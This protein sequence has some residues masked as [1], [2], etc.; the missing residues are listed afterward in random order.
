MADYSDDYNDGG[1]LHSHDFEDM[2][3]R[4]EVEIDAE[5]EDE[6]RVGGFTTGVRSLDL[7]EPASE[8]LPELVQ[9]EAT[10]AML[11]RSGYLGNAELVDVAEQIGGDVYVFGQEG[12]ELND[13]ASVDTVMGE[14]IEQD[15]DI[16]EDSGD[17]WEP[18]MYRGCATAWGSAD[19]PGGEGDDIS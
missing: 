9:E 12:S 10:A 4:T 18:S 16:G 15:I 3:E 7:D 14:D 1:S 11:P 19:D 5:I 2:A 17:D 13:G 6:L 8:L